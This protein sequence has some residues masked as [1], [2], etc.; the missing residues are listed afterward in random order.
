M[1]L[2]I[3]RIAFLIK[4][5]I[6]AFDDKM[7]WYFFSGAVLV[8]LLREILSALGNYYR[9]IHS[10]L[11][12]DI[13]ADK[14]N[15]KTIELDLAHF[16]DYRYHDLL[17]RIKQDVL[18]R[19]KALTENITNLLQYFLAG[20]LLIVF[21]MFFNVWIGLLMLTAVIPGLYVNM[22]FSEKLHTRKKQLSEDER[23]S[24]YY[25]GLLSADIFIKEIKSL[26]TGLFFAESFNQ[27]RKKLYY[28]DKKIAKSK[29]IGELIARTI[30]VL[31]ITGILLIVIN[32]TANQVLSIGSFVMIYL[33]FR[34]G[35]T[36]LKEGSKALTKLY[37][38]SLFLSDYEEFMS[39]KSDIL[40]DSKTETIPTKIE[41]IEFKKVYFKYSENE[42][43]VLKDF[44]VKF[45]AGENVLLSG[46]NGSGKTTFI[47]LLCRLYEPNSGEIEVNG[48]DYTKFNIIDWRNSISVLFQDFARYNMSLHYNITLKP[49]GEISDEKI[50][51]LLKMVNFKEVQRFKG[52]YNVGLG[53]IFKNSLELSLGEWQKIAIV[54]TLYGSKSLMIFDEPT[55]YIDNS[56][57]EIIYK[58][59]TENPGDKIMLTVSHD[60]GMRKY[61]SKVVEF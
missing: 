31:S 2:I 10:N 14:I 17:A 16:E 20:F 30:S 41:S 25:A 45:N 55:A 46:D 27:I 11:V 53:K 28:A 5:E 58:R 12:N 59:I 15:R 42:E 36:F 18:F 54:R 39:L 50:E 61:F 51:E 29:N 48:I 13:I 43:Y 4:N 47:K 60:S 23:I 32:D 44:S 3:D 22:I 34:N 6:P 38:D 9:R 19:P 7:I 57:R 35:L 21:V 8:M 33:I 49:A 24:R 37:E 26:L 1:K 52:N 40:P 56:S